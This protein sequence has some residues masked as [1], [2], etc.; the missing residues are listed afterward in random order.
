M[1]RSLFKRRPIEVPRPVPMPPATHRGRVLGL[2][3]THSR[4]CRPR[5]AERLRQLGV[6]NCG[7]L[8][9]IDLQAVADH[10]RSRNRALWQLRMYRR[11]VRL[12]TSVDG[13]QPADA[14]ILV[15]I[16]RRT[17]SSLARSESTELTGDIR[18]FAETSVGRGLMAGRRPPGAKRVA[19]WIAAAA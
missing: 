1:F 4:L 14:L 12:A 5:R 9:D 8:L 11:A 7:D 13:L 18:R 2:S 19:R 16:H 10:F 17:S 15:A 6:H 3:L